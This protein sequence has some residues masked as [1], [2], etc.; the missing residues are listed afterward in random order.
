MIFSSRLQKRLHN[1][2]LSVKGRQTN[3]GHTREGAPQLIEELPEEET[4]AVKMN[5]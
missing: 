2:R 1:G 5:L 4:P 3:F